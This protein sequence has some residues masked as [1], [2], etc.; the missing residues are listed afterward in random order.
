MLYAEKLIA[1]TTLKIK[2]RENSFT[3][4]VEY[5]DLLN[6]YDYFKSRRKS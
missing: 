4:F 1:E 2:S 3:A 6:T 5:E